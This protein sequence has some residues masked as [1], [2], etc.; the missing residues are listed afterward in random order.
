MLEHN[1][2]TLSLIRHGQSIVNADP[3][4]M[5][6]SH[7]TPLS[8][9]GRDQSAKL[10]RR[11]VK[12][13]EKFDLAF[14]ST[15]KRAYDTALI[16]LTYDDN[17]VNKIIQH[18]DL[19]EYNAGDWTGASRAA[20]LTPEIKHSMGNYDHCFLPP[21]GESLH[22][23]ERRASKWLEDNILYNVKVIEMSKDRPV[24]IAVYSHGMTIKSLLHYIMGFDKSFTWKVSIENTSIS[25]VSFGKDGWRLYSI[26]DYSHL[27]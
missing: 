19:R 4:K 26:N 20:T 1:Q 10:G 22:Q 17:M 7:D 9:R 15:Y 5:G 21:N 27:Y 11:F 18:E 8:L 6:Q 24:N 14:A 16:S 25:K 3:D 13:E 23:V 12:M 2:F